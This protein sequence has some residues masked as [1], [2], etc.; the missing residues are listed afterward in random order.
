MGG[1]GTGSEVFPF[2]SFQT[3]KRNGVFYPGIQLNE[4][5]MFPSAGKWNFFLLNQSLGVFGHVY[6]YLVQSIWTQHQFGLVPPIVLE[7]QVWTQPESINWLIIVR[8]DLCLCAE[9]WGGL[10]IGVYNALIGYQLSKHSTSLYWHL[11][12]ISRTYTTSWS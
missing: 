9:N 12:V 2:S 8:C 5:S 3:R 11:L 6:K 4:A 10:S 1:K 7:N